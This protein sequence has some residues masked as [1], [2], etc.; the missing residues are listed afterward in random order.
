[1]LVIFTREIL[2]APAEKN[3]P[4]PWEAWSESSH[5]CLLKGRREETSLRGLLQFQQHQLMN[6]T[7]ARGNLLTILV[8]EQFEN[9]KEDSCLAAPN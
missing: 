7:A 8:L 1:M 9:A 6:E 3:K 2:T 5:R 4:E